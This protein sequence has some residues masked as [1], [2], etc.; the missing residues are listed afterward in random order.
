LSKSCQKV[1]KNLGSPG[2]SQKK[3]NHPE[4]KNKN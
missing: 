1:V 2:N 4:N 3:V